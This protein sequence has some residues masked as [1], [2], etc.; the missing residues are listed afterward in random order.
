MS[1]GITSQRYGPNSHRD[2]PT[3][4]PQVY[5]R[6]GSPILLRPPSTIRQLLGRF[7]HPKVD[8][9]NVAA[10]GLGAGTVVLEYQPVVHRLRL[11]ASP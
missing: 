7:A 10:L 1:L 4:L 9:P 5:H 3:R 6:L 8:S 2:P 11:S